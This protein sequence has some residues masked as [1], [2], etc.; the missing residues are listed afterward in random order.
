VHADF[1][2]QYAVKRPNNKFGRVIQRSEQ[3]I[4]V[5]LDSA[6]NNWMDSVPLHC[7]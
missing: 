3:Q 5:E 7:T 2:L 6:M 1:C 4:I